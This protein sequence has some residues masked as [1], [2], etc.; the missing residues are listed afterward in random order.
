VGVLVV[1]WF[2]DPNRYKPQIEAAVREATG[3]DFAL[4]GEIELGFF[5]WLA[6]RAGEGRFGNPPGFG[7]EPMVSWKSAQVGAKLVPLLRGR[8]AAGRVTLRG[9]DARLVRRAD[10]RANWEGI[11]TGKPPQPDAEPADFH[12]DGVALEDA[13]ISYVDEV[14]A[15]QVT[16]L[17]SR[18]TTDG[19]APGE[20]LIDTE[21][22]GTLHMPGFQTAGVGFML[23]V[24]LVQLPADHSS[25]EIGEYRVRFGDFEAEGR[26]AGT[27]GERPNLSGAIE[28]DAFD[29]RV[30]LR[31]VG[32]TP[33][34]TTDPNALGRLGFSASWTFDAGAIVIA[35]LTL[36]IDDSK[37]S[38]SFRLGSGE[39]AAGAIQ[40]T[41]DR[42]DIA[43]YIPP[44]DPQSEPFVLPTAMLR[45]LRYHG[46]IDLAEATL[47]DVVMKGVT[48][49]L[50]LDDQGLRG[51]SPAAAP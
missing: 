4:V 46:R 41:G 17:I 6:L 1:V 38:G 12:I 26:V 21:I 36:E 29:P 47:G 11:G 20:P 45:D 51:A 48:L 31:A 25:V 34:Q 44:D 27:L 24:P 5:P 10:G 18:F 2:V 8:L 35:P 3:R 40:L 7:P 43:R 49:H 14:A 39:S 50:V 13:R 30:V 22:E 37:F 33:P 9:L 19:I 16:V 28:A 42:L 23:D 15:Q 32:I